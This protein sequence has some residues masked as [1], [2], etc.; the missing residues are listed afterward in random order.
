MCEKGKLLAKFKGQKTFTENDMKLLK[1][2]GYTFRLF[3]KYQHLMGELK[4]IAE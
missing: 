4:I 1:E 2:I 3:S